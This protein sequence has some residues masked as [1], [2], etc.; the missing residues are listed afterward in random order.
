MKIVLPFPDAILSGHA[1][2]NGQWKKVKITKEYRAE[3]K[4]K[5]ERLLEE[6]KVVIGDGLEKG[7]ADIAI[8]IRF[9]PPNNRGDRINYPAR[10]KP[11]V[12]GIA[13]A[14]GVN[15]RRFL[16]CFIYCEADK[17]GC[18]EFFVNL[19]SAQFHQISH[20]QPSGAIPAPVQKKTARA[21]PRKPRS[22]H[23]HNAFEERQA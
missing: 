8:T 13:D 18:V 4:A 3:A 7:K 2:G 14:L 10:I 19:S 17:P 16:P 1:K 20:R 22:G 15:D 9:I 23:V 12:D 6:M 5:A 21:A 11:Y